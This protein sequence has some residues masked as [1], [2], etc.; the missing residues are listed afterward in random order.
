MNISI[1]DPT[2]S[3]YTIPNL[4]IPSGVEYVAALIDSTG[5]ANTQTSGAQIVQ[6]GKEDCFGASNNNNVKANDVEVV[7][8]GSTLVKC[9][10]TT[11][12]W[13]EEYQETPVT[14]IGMTPGGMITEMGST[15]GSSNAL[16][17]MMTG[18]ANRKCV[19]SA[20]GRGG[21]KGNKYVFRWIGLTRVAVVDA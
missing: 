16:R 12:S 10:L 15:S 18:P 3:S 21:G 7:M 8:T 14:L 11:A 5:Y 19:I 17:I 4:R 6:P 2:A 1:P 13:P 20:W 9:Q